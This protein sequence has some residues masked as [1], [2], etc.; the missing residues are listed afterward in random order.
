[1]ELTPGKNTALFNGAVT[2]ID[3]DP[4][5]LPLIVNGRTMLPL[6]FVVE[7]LG[8]EVSY[9]QATKTITITHTKT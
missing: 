4:K 8:A 6:R 5:V 1:L 3:V 7:S 2:P 9:N